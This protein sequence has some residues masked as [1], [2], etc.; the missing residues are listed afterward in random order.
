MIWMIWSWRKNH[1]WKIHLLIISNKNYFNQ[2]QKCD[3]CGCSIISKANLVED[4]EPNSSSCK[5]ISKYFDVG[6]VNTPNHVNISMGEPALV[7]P[8]SFKNIETILEQLHENAFKKFWERIAVSWSSRTA[9]LLDE[10][11]A[12]K[13]TIWLWLGFIGFWSWS[14][15]YVNLLKTFFKIPEKI[16]LEPLGKEILR[17]NTQKSF[18]YFIN[19]KDNH[20]TWQAFDVFLNG[21]IME[22]IR[23]NCAK[24]INTPTLIGFL[25]WQ[26]TVESR[27]LKLVC[28][29]ILNNGLDLYI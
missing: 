24:E 2:K 21:K 4:S 23:I 13:E 28:E 18:D 9:I 6:K 27:V 7:N 11:V 16:I 3:E 20:K 17:Y 10:K 25:N 5:I 15:K 12:R 8:N 19:F 14:F 1:F 29:L 26:S 22:L